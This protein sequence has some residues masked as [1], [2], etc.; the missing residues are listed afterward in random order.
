MYLRG[1]S[2]GTDRTGRTGPDQT[3][4][5]SNN[6]LELDNNTQIGK[7]INRWALTD[8]NDG[9]NVTNLLQ[10]R[11]CCTNNTTMYI[12]LPF[13]DLNDNTTIN[14]LKYNEVKITV[15]EDSDDIKNL[16]NFKLSV[17]LENLL[18]N[19]FTALWTFLFFHQ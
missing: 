12:S 15:F 5:K 8:Y 2:I 13:I 3:P 11:A 10:K 9:T 6:T 1:N 14:Y 7:L 16:C 19:K 4:F 18:Q 17:L